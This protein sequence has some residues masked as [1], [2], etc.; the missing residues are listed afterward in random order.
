MMKRKEAA[1][2]TGI[3]CSFLW[4]SCHWFW[5]FFIQIA[6]VQRSVPSSSSSEKQAPARLDCNMRKWDNELLFPWRRRRRAQRGD[7]MARQRSAFPSA[8]M[9]TARWGD[10]TTARWHV[11]MSFACRRTF[12]AGSASRYFAEARVQVPPAAD[13]SWS[14][15]MACPWPDRV[16]ES[17]CKGHHGGQRWSGL[18]E[19]DG[20]P[21][22]RA[23]EAAGESG[24]LADSWL[25]GSPIAEGRPTGGEQEVGGRATQD[26][27]HRRHERGRT[28]GRWLAASYQWKIRLGTRL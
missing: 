28:A 25:W 9:S 3:S 8:A 27:Q 14:S 23:L 7:T 10:D 21:T 16:G 11:S 4:N 19:A 13:E 1:F 20:M 22:V 5:I 2:L 24:R 26:W 15:A 6:I 12:P 17:S 18:L